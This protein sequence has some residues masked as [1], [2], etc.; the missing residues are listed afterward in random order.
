MLPDSLN[1]SC[2]CATIFCYAH[3]TIAGD[4]IWNTLPRDIHERQYVAI[5]TKYE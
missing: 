5:Y 1:T 3:F 2:M 4:N